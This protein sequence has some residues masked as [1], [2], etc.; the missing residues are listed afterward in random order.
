MQLRSQQLESAISTLI[1][2]VS[3]MEDTLKELNDVTSIKT[4][5]LLRETILSIH[6]DMISMRHKIESE[7]ILKIGRREK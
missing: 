4:Q 2:T 6:L 1:L 3:T 5:F 7:Q